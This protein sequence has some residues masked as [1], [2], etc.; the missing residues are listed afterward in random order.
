M[1]VSKGTIWGLVECSKLYRIWDI[2]YVGPGLRGVGVFPAAEPGFAGQAGIDGQRLA[3][4][5]SFGG[6]IAGVGKVD[7]EALRRA[8]KG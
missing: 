5:T 4:A 8:Q 2:A 6:Q 7:G 3:G 1:Y